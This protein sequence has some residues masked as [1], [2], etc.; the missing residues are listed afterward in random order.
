MSKKISEIPK[1]LILGKTWVMLAHRYVPV[2]VELKAARPLEAEP[3]SH[4][5]AIFYAFR[6][7]GVEMPI[8]RKQA[9]KRRLKQL[10][11]K[12][13]T[14]VIIEETPENLDAHTG[15]KKKR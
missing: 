6:P 11:K 12:G 7:L 10:E 15:R 1:D 2:R 3:A 8:W 4:K 9:S 13:I 14:P 5:P